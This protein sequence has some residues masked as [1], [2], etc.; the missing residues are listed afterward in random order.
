MNLQTYN[1]TKLL[2][3]V[4]FFV[5]IVVVYTHSES[6]ETR[7]IGT[8]IAAFSAAFIFLLT[9]IRGVVKRT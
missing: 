8:A 4:T 3:A 9:S 2:L 7:K 6:R 1:A 5:A